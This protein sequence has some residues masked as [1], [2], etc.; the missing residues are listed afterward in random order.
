[1]SSVTAEPADV[2]GNTWAKQYAIEKELADKVRQAP[3]LQR[4][5]QYRRSGPGHSETPAG[6]LGI[7]SHR[8]R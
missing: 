2:T 7:R 6:R 5:R 1:M 8:R 4:G 3:R